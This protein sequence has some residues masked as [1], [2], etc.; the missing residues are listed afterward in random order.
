MPLHVPDV[1]QWAFEGG[2]RLPDPSVPGAH[3]ALIGVL[4]SQAVLQEVDLQH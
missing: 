2:L 1:Q 4:G 3:L